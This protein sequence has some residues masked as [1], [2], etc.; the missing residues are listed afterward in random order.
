M[1]DIMAGHL[2]ICFPP[3]D[4]AERLF[5]QQADSGHFSKMGLR[6]LGSMKDK[7]A[8]LHLRQHPETRHSLHLIEVKAGEENRWS[9]LLQA[10]HADQAKAT[11]SR[12]QSGDLGLSFVAAPN[13]VAK[14]AGAMG[15][16]VTVSGK[17][18]TFGPKY[19][20]YQAMTGLPGRHPS[21]KIRILLVDTGI[22]ADAKVAVH[23]EKNII[24]PTVATASDDNGHGTAIALVIDDLAPG[25][26][27]VVFKAGNANG[28]VNEWDVL[29]AMVA[30]AGTD[31]INLSVE[32]G[33][34]DRTCPTCGRQSSSSRSA[35]FE[36]I[37]HATA[38]WSKRPVV[39]AAA[40][41]GNASNLAYPARFAD[42][43][44]AGSVNSSKS[45]AHESNYGDT[46]HAGNQH[47]NHFA[48]PG[49][50][51]DPSN[52]EYVIELSNNKQYRGTSFAAAFI[53]A[54]VAVTMGSQPPG[55][56]YKSTLDAMRQKA[57]SNFVAYASPHHG[58][59]IVHT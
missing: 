48:A 52:P 54:A 9:A 22:A 19:S 6:Y 11:K 37:L 20:A 27:F 43:I 31:I 39:V 30:D 46:D 35:I 53:S 15:S 21:S 32:Y 59:G 29:A 5:L 25:T 7:L 18:F 8:Q 58:N 4:M 50:D 47:N 13:Y 45:L 3:E 56:S 17:N 44:A 41:N 57:D 42:V 2:I 51:S 1:C 23:S 34:G 33:L 55:Y 38:N 10:W 26:E 24:D 28:D 49:G 16:G 36:N 12:W 40:G 14:I